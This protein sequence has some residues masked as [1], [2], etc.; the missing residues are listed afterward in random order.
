MLAVSHES[1]YRWVYRSI[2][3][4]SDCLVP[5]LRSARV[6]RHRWRAQR[7]LQA[8]RQRRPLA[9]WPVWVERRRQIGHFEA[10]LVLSGS[11]QPSALLTLVERRT[12]AVLIR[13]VWRK[14][15]NTVT[16]AIVAAV[17][18]GTAVQG[19]RLPTP[20]ALAKSD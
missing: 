2:A 19:L 10:D 1:I 15:A 6:A 16:R 3:R 7:H 20:S 5:C 17:G 14:D 4:G 13:R 9:Q 8:L 11:H 18:A 12:G